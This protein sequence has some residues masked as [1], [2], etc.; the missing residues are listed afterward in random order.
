MAPS[1]DEPPTKPPHLRLEPTRS[2]RTVLD[3]CWWPATTD[4]AAEL[5]SLVRAIDD[6]HGPVRR[7][8]LSAAGWSRRPHDIDVDDRVV[9]LGYF[10]DQPASLLTASCA[11]GDSV[12]LMVVPPATES[13]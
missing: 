2:R 10:S 1:I 4:P 13:R 8:M 6:L 3:G 7:L 12:E 9:S 11:D 5:P